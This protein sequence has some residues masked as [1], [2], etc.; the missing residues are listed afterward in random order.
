M[1]GNV[2]SLYGA[3]RLTQSPRVGSLHLLATGSEKDSLQHVKTQSLHAL[4][5]QA[6]WLEDYAFPATP[7][8]ESHAAEMTA[9]IST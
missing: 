1:F 3:L 5:T 2:G 8:P 7:L 6:L 9:P 4:L